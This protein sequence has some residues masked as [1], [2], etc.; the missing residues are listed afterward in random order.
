MDVTARE[1]IG[2]YRMAD[3]SIGGAN[4]SEA[5]HLVDL[6]ILANGREPVCVSAY[7]LRTNKPDP[8]AR[9]SMVASFRLTG[10]SVDN[11]TYCTVESKT[12][13]AER[14]TPICRGGLVTEDFKRLTLSGSLLPQA[15]DW[16]RV[17]S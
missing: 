7:S 14:A 1:Y 9:N 6:D 17:V 5:C 3:P 2:S 11:L 4:L 10:G 15:I 13:G 12:S 16:K 8:I